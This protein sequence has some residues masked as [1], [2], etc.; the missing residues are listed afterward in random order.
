VTS[1]GVVGNNTLCKLFM[2]MFVFFVQEVRTVLPVW[3]L[4][5]TNGLTHD[6]SHYSKSGA[7][8]N[9]IMIAVSWFDFYYTGFGSGTIGTMLLHSIDS[10]VSL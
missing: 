6:E 2:M 5:H 7:S 9:P 3:T 8:C 4:S 10:A 1:F